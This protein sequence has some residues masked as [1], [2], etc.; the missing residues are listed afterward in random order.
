MPIT[1]IITMPQTI[2]IHA[3]RCVLPVRYGTEDIPKDFPGRE[4]DVLT[5]TIDLDGDTFGHVRDWPHPLTADLHMKVIDEGR[6]Y[7]LDSDDRVIAQRVDDYVPG[8]VCQTY[9]KYFD[10]C[11]G[12]NGKVVLDSVD[13]TEFVLEDCINETI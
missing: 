7:L 12:A 11:I 6:Y 9:C 2:E 10:L 5:I 1:K 4:G 13:I 8:C 3:L